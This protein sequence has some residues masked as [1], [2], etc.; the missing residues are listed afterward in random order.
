MIFAENR[1]TP[2]SLE[3]PNLENNLFFWGAELLNFR[4][5]CCFPFVCFE[6]AMGAVYCLNI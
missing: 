6:K 3:I 2:G 5:V 1:R 4:R